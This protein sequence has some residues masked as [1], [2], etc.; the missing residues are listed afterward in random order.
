MKIQKYKNTKI[1]GFTLIEVLISIGI[2]AL[3]TGIFYAN[4]RGA[5]I[6]TDLKGAAQKLA[7]DIRLAQNFSLGTK[8]FNESTPS[9]GWGVYFDIVNYPDSYLIFADKNENFEYDEHNNEKYRT[10]N[11][12]ANISLISLEIEDLVNPANIVFLPPDPQVYINAQRNQNIQ[13]TIRE[14]INNT[15]KI[16]EVNFLGLID[17]KE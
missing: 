7:N 1:S 14:I 5:G 4:Y 9:G 6:R 3:L 13:I 16:I 17:V 2:I 15:T 12:P 11:L 10:I 8:E